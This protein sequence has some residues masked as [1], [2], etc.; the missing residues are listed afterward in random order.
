MKE[1]L[2]PSFLELVLC[3]R[4]FTIKEALGHSFLEFVPCKRLFTIKEDPSSS[5]LDLVLCKTLFTIEEVPIQCALSPLLSYHTHM[6]EE[7][8]QSAVRE[9]DQPAIFPQTLAG[10]WVAHI[11]EVA[12]RLP[13]EKQ[14]CPRSATNPGSQ[15][16]PTS[17]SAAPGRLL[18]VTVSP[19]PACQRTAALRLA[20]CPSLSRVSPFTFVLTRAHLPAFHSHFLTAQSTGTVFLNFFL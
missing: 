17:C 12:H 10:R 3:R 15:R 11:K 18:P 16:I 14:I 1:A 8:Q 9:A 6:K 2:C 20:I 7:A 4:L 13:R 19:L 5:I